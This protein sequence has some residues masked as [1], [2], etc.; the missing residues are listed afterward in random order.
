MV[1]LRECGQ[2]RPPGASRPS[3][4][5]R[6]W[7]AVSGAAV[8]T[9]LT[10]V[11][12]GRLDPAY[13]VYVRGMSPCTLPTLQNPCCNALGLSTPTE[14]RDSRQSLRRGPPHEDARLT[15]NVAHV[16]S[17][18]P[19]HPGLAHPSPAADDLAVTPSAPPLGAECSLSRELGINNLLECKPRAPMQAGARRR[20]ARP[21]SPP[22]S[23][24]RAQ[25]TSMAA[26]PSPLLPG[27]FRPTA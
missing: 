13:D 23:L 21:L 24:L 19:S 5:S 25:A 10:C 1:E 6:S 2:R 16:N 11:A 14:R 8:S 4:P 9:T 12:R 18:H 26:P 7:A 3:G 15:P 20:R 27:H 17:L 22:T